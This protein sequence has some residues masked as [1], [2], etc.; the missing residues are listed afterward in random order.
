M[1]PNLDAASQESRVQDRS[2]DV[3]LSARGLVKQFPVRKTSIRPSERQFVRAVD[4]VDLD[5]R[6]GQTL[7]IVG[8]SGSGKS[9]LARLLLALDRPTAGHVLVDGQDPFEL[10]RRELRRARRDIQIVMQDPYTS[11]DPRM[12]A[13]Q[14]IAEPFK[15]HRDVAPT[16]TRAAVQELL[17][18]VGLNPDHVNRYPHQFSGGQR[19]RIGIARAIALRPKIVVCDEAVSALDVSVQAQVLN[20]LSDLQQELDLS[21]IFIAHD[22]SVVEHVSDEVAVMYLGR[23]VE[24]GTTVQ[25]YDKALHPYTQAL[26]SAVPSAPGQSRRDRI[27][28]EGEIPSPLDMPSGCVFRTRCWKATD[29]CAQV[30]PV[31]SAGP[32]ASHPA[33][34]HYAKERV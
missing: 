16:N 18:L 6:R 29:L 5:L 14:I 11:L 32:S 2:D 19:Q 20:L 24:R 22:L 12:T 1:T 28:L 8:E 15:L 9:T 7:G 25:V 10:N 13:G 26:L 3:I 30:E 4:G 31:L 23:I 21:Y 34:C 17:E 27:L 33:A